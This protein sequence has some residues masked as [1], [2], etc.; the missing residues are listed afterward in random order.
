LSYK[1]TLK[2]DIKVK[3]NKTDE[4]Q[5]YIKYLDIPPKVWIGFA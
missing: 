3:D 2:T 5:K 1:L 4:V